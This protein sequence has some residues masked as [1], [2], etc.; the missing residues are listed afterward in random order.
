MWHRTQDVQF[1]GHCGGS[2]PTHPP[3]S[4]SPQTHTFPMPH[5]VWAAEGEFKGLA[6]LSSPPPPPRA[7]PGEG[8]PGAPGRTAPAA[9]TGAGPASSCRP[10]CTGTQSALSG[11]AREPSF[12]GGGAPLVLRIDG[13][14]AERRRRHVAGIAQTWAA[15]LGSRA[16]AA[17][18]AL[19][20]LQLTAS[21]EEFLRTYAGVAS[22]Q[23]SQL[24]QHPI[25]QGES[26][27]A[28][29]RALP[30]TRSW[31]L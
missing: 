29:G 12:G 5:Q 25:D 7:L 9:L 1:Q 27:P 3:P 15:A 13:L 16:P 31:P 28:A 24:P 21:E 4:A 2:L 17:H 20:P 18:A 26:R 23:L 8:A 11:P 22:S 30:G 14:G 6:F 10:R 19:S